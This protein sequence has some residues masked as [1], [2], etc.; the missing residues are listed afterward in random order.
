MNKE[1]YL[2]N[3][4]VLK[5]AAAGHVI[6]LHGH[7]HQRMD[8]LSAEEIH[9]QITLSQKIM[10]DI[11]G[12]MPVIFSPPGGFIS[13]GVRNIALEHGVRVIRTMRWG[14]N[15]QVDL[16]ALETIPINRHTHDKKFLKILEQRDCQILY[17]AK[18]TLK[19][20]VP[21]RS[22]EWLRGLVFKFSKN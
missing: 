18:E 7:E 3:D 10:T 9:R 20:L 21:L 11:T 4:Q 17:T 1:G 16:T 13:A 19:R 15:K 8:L 22:Y 14:Y 6:G 5:L 12:V 2:T